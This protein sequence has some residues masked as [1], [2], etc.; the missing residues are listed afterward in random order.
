MSTIMLELPDDTKIR[1]GDEVMI[2][3]KVVGDRLLA[4]SVQSRTGPSKDAERAAAIDEFLRVW[5]G[6]A[7]RDWSEQEIEQSRHEYLQR[8][9]LR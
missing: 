5:G 2:H 1:D 8:K 6:D 3:A 9:H 7:T 4:E